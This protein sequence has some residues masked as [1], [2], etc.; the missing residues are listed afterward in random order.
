MSFGFFRGSSAAAPMPVATPVAVTMSPAPLQQATYT[1]SPLF[2]YVDPIYGDDGQAMV[3]NPI[4]PAVNSPA[5]H[6]GAL[7]DPHTDT[8][9]VAGFLQH[10]PYSFK[11]VTAALSYVQQFNPNGPLYSNSSTQVQL[12]AIVIHCLPGLYGPVDEAA[13]LALFDPDS[14]LPFNDESFPLSIPDHVSIQG[15]SALDTI[16][17]A[18][19]AET[20]IFEFMPNP[21][22]APIG[23]TSH[24]LSF[25]DGV[26]IRNAGGST[27]PQGA[28]IYVSCRDALDEYWVDIRPKFSNC[29]IT[30][31][32]VGIAVHGGLDHIEETSP[33]GPIIFNNT[34]AWNSIG[35]WN[36]QLGLMGSQSYGW[37]QLCV[38]N[39]IFDATP[40]TIPATTSG[41]A[42]EGMHSDDMLAAQ[43]GA[44]WVCFNAWEYYAPSLSS[45]GKAN[46][47]GGGGA[48]WPATQ[49]RPLPAPA[50]PLT[51]MAH[52][53]TSI[54]GITGAGQ[55]PQPLRGILYVSDLLQA[56]VGNPVSPHDFRLS[57]MVSAN[58]QALTSLSPVVDQGTFS[59]P[60]GSFKNGLQTTELG[61]ANPL[62]GTAGTYLGTDVDC[63]GF[64]NPRS[65]QHAGYTLL[66][67]ARPDLGADELDNLLIA[68]FLPSTR[69]LSRD[70]PT[71]PPAHPSIAD[72][73]EILFVNLPQAT[74]PRPIYNI[75]LSE[76]D[77]VVDLNWFSQ[78]VTNPNPPQ[79]VPASNYT[80]GVVAHRTQFD[81]LYGFTPPPN[82][83]EKRP[84]FMRNLRCDFSPHPLMD[85]HPL[86]PEWFKLRFNPKPL[87]TDPV[88]YYAT[89]PW[90][91]DTNYR[92]SISSLED[93]H[94]DN[95]FLYYDPN[96]GP[97]NI[98]GH[99][100]PPGTFHN[101]PAVWGNYLLWEGWPT[102]QLGPWNGGGSPSYATDQWGVGDATALNTIDRVPED[103]SWRGVRYN[104]QVFFG[105]QGNP[106]VPYMSNLQT[107]LGVNGEQ[108]LPPALRGG[109]ETLSAASAKDYIRPVGKQPEG[110]LTDLVRKAPW[111]RGGGK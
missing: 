38:F 27:A 57:P 46:L 11:T 73:T 35:L 6:Q 4:N 25:I 74:Y 16:F 36:G 33:S 49:P 50:V 78:L 62:A 37:A 110:D 17:D 3:L 100:N 66:P 47:G 20:H 1:Q 85:L 77:S 42:F 48:S 108:I 21:V 104:A 30:G 67:V 87:G 93:P 61:L 105:T 18:R 88:G 109:T 106:A 101:N 54:A 98:S 28:G 72:H 92:V 75:S 44:T 10:A 39:N 103:Q 12:N 102:G 99:L 90:V 5:N 91:R 65:A 60:S 71:L 14:G 40:Y 76:G 43:P 45:W 29:F 41:S 2:V 81:A 13:G 56:R 24:V 111:W 58:R 63:E 86:W 59:I 51:P 9:Q 26:T 34:L 79:F 64:G 52:G 97:D 95:E 68:G 8:G 19:G 22:K 107:F 31:N 7:F 96:V 70:D 55:T 69:I 53:V 32:V 89:N 84:N 15:T 83:L 23:Q 82:P 94:P 80:N